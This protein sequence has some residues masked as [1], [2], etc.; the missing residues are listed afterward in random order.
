MIDIHSHIL[1]DVDDGALGMTET[2][3][4]ARMSVADGVTHMFATPHHIHFTPLHRQEVIG[5]VKQVQT[6]LDAA[7]IPLTV[8]PGHEVRLYAGTL[9]DW[10]NQMAGPLG[11]SRYILTEPSFYHY[12]R[13]T[14]AILFEFFNQ[15]YT[16]VLAHPERIIPIQQKLSLIEPVLARGAL[17][18]ITA[19]SLTNRPTYAAR[20]VAEEMLRQGMVHII[21]SDAHNTS[22]RRPGLSMA[23]DRAAR[24]VGEKQANAMVTTIPKAILND[25]LV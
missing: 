10:E 18:Q 2:L 5:R 13:Y 8:L 14:N 3:A 1:P 17:V 20:I 25:E 7:H 22:Y 16:P 9:H 23:R 21:A 6:Q 12:D 15:G 11:Y 19:N 24:I 4:M